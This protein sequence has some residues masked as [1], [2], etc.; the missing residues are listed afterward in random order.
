MNDRQLLIKVRTESETDAV[1]V[2]RSYFP[3]W[4]AEV[5]GKPAEVR[6]GENAT[7][8]VQIP[9]GESAVG[10]QFARSSEMLMGDLITLVSFVLLLG[11]M[12]RMGSSHAKK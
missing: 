9:Q 11:C 5:N 3:G 2:A 4:E 10:L 6:V 12:V 8:F 7:M 1:V